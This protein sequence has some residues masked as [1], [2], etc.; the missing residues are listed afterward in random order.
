MKNADIRNLADAELKTAIADNQNA[1]VRL[2]FSHAISAIE[3]PS[4]IRV[5]RRLIARLKTE[6]RAR[7]LAKTNQ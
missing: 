2:K 7:Q 5:L 1:L 4:S 6:Q 3:N